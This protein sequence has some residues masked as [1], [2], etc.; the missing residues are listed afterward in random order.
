MKI[1]K[2]KSEKKTVDNGLDVYEYLK[3]TTYPIDAAVAVFKN[4]KHPAKINKGFFELFY[5]ID[6]VLN[7]EINGKIE[8]LNQGDV[9]MVEPN[10]LHKIFAD[11]A[12][13]FIVCNPPFNPNN[14][15]MVD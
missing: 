12:K 9:F 3:D 1:S 7:I 13:V 8:E 5:I 6:G 15:E 10:K 4:A 2:D 11:F 14:I